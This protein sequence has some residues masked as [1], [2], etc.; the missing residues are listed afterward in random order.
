MSE[1]P[2]SAEAPTLDN[3][4]PRQSPDEIAEA[5]WRQMQASPIFS[6]RLFGHCRPR[7]L[8]RAPI[9]L[10]GISGSFFLYGARGERR[11]LR[12]DDHDRAGIA[13]L[14]AGAEGWLCRLWP[15]GDGGWD[16]ERASETL[17]HFQGC[18]GVVDAAALGFELPPEP[19]L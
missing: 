10:Y 19:L 11:A 12:P 7:F 16:D 2:S 5:A 18:I 15:D 17:M 6:E 1:N 3:R 13:T 4:P 8:E 9:R 14:F